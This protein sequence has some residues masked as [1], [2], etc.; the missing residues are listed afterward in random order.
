MLL[1]S[2]IIKFCTSR[3]LLLLFCYIHIVLKLHYMQLSTNHII[4]LLFGLDKKKII[5]NHVFYVQTLMLARSNPIVKTF[6]FQLWFNEGGSQL[7]ITQFLILQIQLDFQHDPFN[8]C[9]LPQDYF[10]DAFR[11]LQDYLE[12][13]TCIIPQK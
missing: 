13:H 8:I 11:S 12:R 4:G 6:L 7:N 5:T 10:K 9:K 3:I 2:I 1:W